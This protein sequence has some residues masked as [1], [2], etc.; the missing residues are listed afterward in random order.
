MTEIRLRPMYRW[1]LGLG[2]AGALILMLPIRV[3]EP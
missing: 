1:L 2:L 3:A